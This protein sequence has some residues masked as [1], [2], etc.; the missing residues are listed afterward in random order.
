MAAAKRPPI[1]NAPE[2][3]ANAPIIETAGETSTGKVYVY[4]PTTK[5][6]RTV[7][8]AEGAAAVFT[9]GFL[10][11]SERDAESIHAQRSLAESVSVGEAVG[12]GLKRAATLGLSDL[13]EDTDGERAVLEATEAAHP[14]ITGGTELAGTVG[15][16][17]LTLGGSGLLRGAAALSPVGLTTLAGEGVA[18]G[19]G[20]GGGVARTALARGVGAGVEGALYGGAQAFRDAHLDDTPL[21]AQR[22]MSGIFGGF[23]IGAAIG[24]P[25]GAA[26][27]ALGV[28]GRRSLIA[29]RGAAVQGDL[30]AI[31]RPGL[32]DADAVAIARAHGL[33]GSDG[34]LRQAVREFQA[35]NYDSPHVTPDL[36]QLANAPGEL[37]E[38][39][40]AELFTEGQRLR[41]GAEERLRGSLDQLF[42]GDQVAIGGWSGR[43]KR[44]QVE[45][46][47]PES[48][49]KDDAIDGF[50]E[51]NRL[52]VEE[53]AAVAAE[54]TKRVQEDI[55]LNPAAFGAMKTSLGVDDKDFLNVLEKGIYDGDR[56]VAAALF[57]SGLGNN[58]TM[59]S[60]TRRAGLH[61][62][63]KLEAL[64]LVDDAGEAL[65]NAQALPKGAFSEGGQGK[66]KEMLGL[67]AVERRAI[68]NGSRADVFSSLDYIKKRLGSYAGKGWLGT[69]DGVQGLARRWHEPFRQALERP[70]LWGD[71]AAG[72]QR[73]MN[74]ILH[75]RIARMS[76]FDSTFFDSTFQPDPRN[77]WATGRR[78]SQEKIRRSM[79]RL[80]DDAQSF[81][82]DAFRTHISESKQLADVMRKH[83]DL[84]PDDMNVVAAL[85]KTSADADKAMTE[86]LHFARRQRQGE[87]LHQVGIAG[88]GF[89]ERAV[90]GYVVGGLPGAVA[91]GAINHLLNPG[92]TLALRAM[93]E[94]ALG[95]HGARVS[96][97]MG[98]LVGGA[99][100]LVGGAA[101]AAGR[102]AGPATLGL[103][104]AGSTLEERNGAYVE[105]L[106]DLNEMAQNR[107][108][109]L[110]AIG[111]RLGHGL[112]QVPGAPS[113]MADSLMRGAQFLL[114]VAP[115]K[116]QT[117]LF[118]THVRLMGDIELDQW[119]KL[120]HAT[121]DPASILESAA[122][123]ELTKDQ[124]FGAS[125]TAP[126]L[127]QD[128]RGQL[129]NFVAELGPEKIPYPAQ[130]QMS[131]LFDVPVGPA[132]TPEYTAFN[133]FVHQTREQMDQPNGPTPVE[134]RTFGETGLQRGSYARRVMSQGDKIELDEVIR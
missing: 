18:A 27:G 111:G 21:T 120:V 54:V 82:L 36:L 133:Q 2:P 85:E 108:A 101:R 59:Q 102:T 34:E 10:P 132:S 131:V 51:V 75:K 15:L 113:M 68:E 22:L 79:D 130:V 4:N 25:L 39:V 81:E 49:F 19:V 30:D 55:A 45:S 77:P 91:M 47:I 28:L 115:A 43:L 60:L 92:H 37:G 6:T 97:A 100:R 66:L 125:V 99:A 87:V 94:R 63:Y 128:L 129:A 89:R 44:K 1:S 3:P 41:A 13:A 86:A 83:Y 42:E 14:F 70:D 8:P 104:T 134:R 35:Q 76:E 103:S 78:A 11:V 123:G 105:T 118:G 58:E 109:V 65:A 127:V 29:R 46:W 53:R 107:E 106:Q 88:T 31:L 50:A 122:A 90:V 117:F 67:L 124:V 69:G 5:E 24:T 52:P 126:E 112:R 20:L 26:E 121:M 71:T 62:K 64:R 72:V 61:P 40:R 93:L 73:E 9:A 96:Q 12:L 38:R 110:R 114:Q 17:A 80:I 33:Q 32:T 16:T 95:S 84:E 56:R 57:G 48:S 98:G 23:G 119:E 116:P 74:A 7:S